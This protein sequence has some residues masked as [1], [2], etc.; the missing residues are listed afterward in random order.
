M[1]V[2]YDYDSNSIHV[3]AMP[4]RTAY[5]ILLAY[6]RAHKLLVSRGLRP[7][8]Q[9]LDN[10]CD[11]ALVHYLNEEEVEFQLVPPHVHRRNAAERA[12]RT[13]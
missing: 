4:S 2:L 13:F 8:L 10:E 1:L 7:R 5:Q 3:E 12:I 6:Q 9:K 11:K